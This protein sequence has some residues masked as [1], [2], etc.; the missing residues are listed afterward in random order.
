MAAGFFLFFLIY[1]SLFG[2]DTRGKR[3]GGCSR[4]EPH[5]IKIKPVTFK[6]CETQLTYEVES[7]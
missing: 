5:K 3:W 7:S 1:I 2:R 6:I 4:T